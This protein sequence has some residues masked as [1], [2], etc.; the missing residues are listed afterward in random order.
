MNKKNLMLVFFPTALI[1]TL[2]LRSYARSGEKLVVTNSDAEATTDAISDS[3]SN[4][5]TQSVNGS[6]RPSRNSKLLSL[7]YSS[8]EQL[9][10]S[11][12]AKSNG[13]SANETFEV[14]EAFG[15]QFSARHYDFYGPLGL[16]LAVGLETT[17]E[18]DHIDY[19]YGGS[20]GKQGVSRSKVDWLPYVEVN[21]FLRFRDLGI[22]YP[23]RI[24]VGSGL[25]YSRG[26]KLTHYISDSPSG[27]MGTQIFFELPISSQWSAQV[28]Y[29]TFLGKDKDPTNTFDETKLAG[30][31]YMFGYEF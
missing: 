8:A 17:R 4:P 18:I 16:G 6:S 10:R 14:D 26:L 11:G 28:G 30:W 2:G 5:A 12:N 3:G 7:Y 15:V 1:L 22:T 24:L 19:N 20:V 13:A 25:N 9:R 21:F 31:Y 29:R 27:K 23:S